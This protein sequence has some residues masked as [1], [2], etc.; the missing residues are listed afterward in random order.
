MNWVYAE[1]KQKGDMEEAIGVLLDKI[2]KN[3]SGETLIWPKRL[4][5]EYEKQNGPG[6]APS[7]FPD[8]TAFASSA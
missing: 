5:G 8:R 6:G 7:A 2:E 3:F 4:C 1:E